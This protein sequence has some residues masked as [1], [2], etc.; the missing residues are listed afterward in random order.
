MKIEN[1]GQVHTLSKGWQSE[2]AE[3]YSPPRI[4]KIASDMG[5]RP[6]WALDLTTNDPEDDMPWDFTMESKRK[7]AMELLNQ[8]QPVLLLVHP[9]C[10]A[11]S[12]TNN[13]NYDKMIP[14]VV[15]SK[16]KAAVQ[17]V[18]FALDLC[19]KQCSKGRLF[20][21]ENHATASSWSTTMM[22]EVLNLEVVFA[23]TL[24]FCQLGMNTTNANGSP[25]AAQ[26]R[27]TVMTNSSNIAEMLW[28]AQCA[29]VHCH[30][31]LVGGKAKGCEVYPDQFVEL[32]CERELK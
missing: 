2:C 11:F 10:G 31:P 22:Q 23:T 27:T 15:Y 14:S 24:D 19:M 28:R 25:V 30:E 29:N 8:D 1:K 13:I 21:F 3:V 16:F 7:R 6:A 12:S 17:H 4:T 9:T 18:K 5:L 20:M 32:I 26:Q